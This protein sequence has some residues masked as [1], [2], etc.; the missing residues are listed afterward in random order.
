MGTQNKPLTKPLFR[1]T[2][3][4]MSERVMV[5]LFS[6]LAGF[7][8][9]A[10]ANGIRTACFV[11]RDERCRA[12][13]AKAYPNIP[14]Y[15][16]VKT[17]DGKQ[18]AGAFLLAGGPPCQAASRAGKQRGAQDDRWL[19][20]H[21]IRCLS[22]IRPTWAIFENVPGLRDLFEFGVQLDVASDGTARGA[23]GT[24]VDRAGRS[25]LD[26][27][28][29]EIEQA[30][31]DVQTLS[32]PACSVGAPHR[33][34]RYW[35]ICRKLADASIPGHTG[36]GGD[37]GSCWAKEGSPENGQHGNTACQLANAATC[38]RI[39]G[40]RH[41]DERESDFERS[42]E[43][44]VGNSRYGDESRCQ[45]E[46]R[47]EGSTA[48]G[49]NGFWHDSVYVPCAD[50]KLRRSIDGS[51]RMAHGLPVELLEAL[52][53]EGRQTPQDCEVH[54]SLLAALGNSIVSEIPRRII[55]AMIQADLP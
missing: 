17:F 49:S 13:L 27:I 24:V 5:D 52:G 31:Y 25:C 35:I 37:R 1:S 47:Q 14:I 21:A 53:T 2:V 26:Q 36:P 12:F 18:Y 39:A 40:K 23:V 7:T 19:W 8:R 16:D 20:G 44:G 29:E 6:G 4:E 15:E 32:I 38:G 22:E 30:G 50:G 46:G 55:A 42:G 28:L 9:A 41:D 43:D 45:E 54:R 10:E 3:C 33:R 34:E 11:E 48:P 51:Q